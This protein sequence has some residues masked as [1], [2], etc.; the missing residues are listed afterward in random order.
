MAIARPV[1]PGPESGEGRFPAAGSQT[2]LAPPISE[3]GMELDATLPA[4]SLSHSLPVKAAIDLGEPSGVFPKLPPDPS[5]PA[6]PD[7]S[8]EPSTRVLSGNPSLDA[9]FE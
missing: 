8:A 6:S 7:S 3:T 9:R 4:A 5:S 2:S 1:V